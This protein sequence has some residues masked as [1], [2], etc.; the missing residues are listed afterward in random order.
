MARG[1]GGKTIFED[2][3]DRLGFLDRLGKVCGSHGWRIHAWVLMGN[4]FHLL[5]ETPEANLVSGMKLLLGGFG[6]AWNRRRKRRGH[7]FQGRYKSVPV[8]GESED[9]FYFRMVADYIHLNPAR[10]GL[11]GGKRG[12]LVDYRWSSLRSYAN[13]KPPEWLEIDRVLKAFE[14]ARDGRGRRAYV[15]WLEAR[16]TQ[17]G[18]V[19][20]EATKALKRGWYLGQPTFRDRLLEMLDSAKNIR[21]KGSQAGAILKDHGEA[22]AERLVGSALQLLGIADDRSELSRLKKGDP[23]KVIVAM[24]LRKRTTV[25]NAWI[26]ER[27]EMG[28]S[29]SVSRTVSEGLKNAGKVREMEKLGRKLA[30]AT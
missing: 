30:L 21:A 6:Q 28:H 7:V 16:A 9:A 20:P 1:D 15:A 18:E 5:V 3:T 24:L 17:G 25:G 2:D 29:S 14:L 8:S 19:N 22:E 27:L 11:A 12:S 10:A 4:H 26:A 23:R 13:G